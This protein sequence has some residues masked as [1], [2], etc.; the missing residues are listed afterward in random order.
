MSVSSSR[1]GTTPYTII[2]QQQFL[3][4]RI[5]LEEGDLFRCHGVKELA[6]EIMKDEIRWSFYATLGREGSTKIT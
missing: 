1:R 6:T 4:T 3:S 2:R 5:V